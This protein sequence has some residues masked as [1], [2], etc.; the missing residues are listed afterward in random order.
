MARYRRQARKQRL[1]DGSARMVRVVV[2]AMIASIVTAGCD[3]IEKDTVASLLLR[4]GIVYDGSGSQPFVADVAILGDQISFVGDAQAAGI[5]GTDELDVSGLLIAP[6]FIDMHSHAALDTDY[7]RDA[8][9]FLHQGITTVVLGVD[10]GGAPEVTLKLERWNKNG[11]GV[12]AMTYVGHGAVRRKVLGMSDRAPSE[13]ELD[14]MTLLDDAAMEQVA[15]GLSTGLF[16]APGYYATTEEVIELARHAAAAGGR[17]AMLARFEDPAEVARLDIE[18]MEM[19][20][21]TRRSRKD[22]VR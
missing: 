20:S 5:T 16:Y 6:G 13:T 18:M 8:L 1:S 21:N 11:V 2:L 12:N 7:G 9:P 14:A 15:I 22:S 10:G 19:R 4:G 3:G 17:E